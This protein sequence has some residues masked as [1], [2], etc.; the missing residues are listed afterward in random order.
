M[1]DSEAHDSLE[2]VQTVTRVVT[3]ALEDDA[4][5][6]GTFTRGS[7]ALLESIGELDLA[8]TARFRLG[9]DRE[10]R[11]VKDVAPDDSEVAGGFLGARLLDEASYPHDRVVTVDFLDGRA[12]V[13]VDLVLRHLHEGH[14]RTAVTDLSVDHLLKEVI[15]LVNEVVT[16]QDS[17][18][19]I[20]DV[21][22][23]DEDGMT[24]TT[25]LPLADEVDV[26]KV[27]RLLHTAQTAL[28]ALLFERTLELPVPVEV[29]LKGGLRAPGD[30]DDVVDAGAYGLFD[31][32]LDR[33]LV[34]HRQ[35]LLGDGFGSGQEPRTK[36]SGRNDSLACSAPRR[37]RRG[38]SHAPRLAAMTRQDGPAN[39]LRAGSRAVSQGLD[40]KT[41]RAQLRAARRAR[42]EQTSTAEKSASGARLAQ[43][44]LNVPEVASAQCIATYEPLPTEPDVA[45]LVAAL[46]S[47][48]QVLVPITLTTLDLSWRDLRTGADLGRDAIALADVILTP[49]QG[50]GPHGERLGQGGGCYDRALPRRRPDAPVIAVVFPDEVGMPIP[51]E[52]HDE[53]VD[54]VATLDGVSWF[55]RTPTETGPHG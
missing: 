26:A 40:K 24:E 15:V 18:R 28:V 29:V 44:L 54:A 35:H 20:A 52:D 49:A 23:A 17:E 55:S 30:R 37:G 10:D 11:R 36:A 1:A 5:D 16:E 14:D 3:A 21:V 27:G 31:D 8:A 6:T 12:P 7:C 19:F 48:T 42:R 50:I 53:P 46:P 33:G 45:Q 9:Q 13:H 34:H 43:I 51:V 4:D 41:L 2:I 47:H 22:T 39:P 25:R 38:I 32:V